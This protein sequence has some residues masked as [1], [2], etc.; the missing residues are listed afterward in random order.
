MDRV[1]LGDTSG[2]DGQSPTRVSCSAF[3]AQPT[4]V[5]VGESMPKGVNMPKGVKRVSNARVK[6]ESLTK[7]GR[8]EARDEDEPERELPLRPRPAHDHEVAAT[9]RAAVS[10][11]SHPLG[12]PAQR[13]HARQGRRCANRENVYDVATCTWLSGTHSLVPDR[14]AVPDAPHGDDVD[15]RAAQDVRNQGVGG[16]IPRGPPMP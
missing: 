11:A 3:G 10:G 9:M 1:G 8:E 12:K 2:A 7:Q 15:A 16:S 13:A 6:S 4:P 14:D 5:A